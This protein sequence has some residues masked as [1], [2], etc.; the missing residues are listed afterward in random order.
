MSLSL[1][2]KWMDVDVFSISNWD[3]NFLVVEKTQ[4]GSASWKG[5]RC[6][7]TLDQCSTWR[8]SEQGIWKSEHPII[9]G[10]GPNLR[11]A[12]PRSH[13]LPP[14][15]YCICL[16][17]PYR[18]ICLYPCEFP[19]W[20]CDHFRHCKVLERV[21]HYRQTHV[22]RP[23]AGYKMSR[24]SWFVL[25]TCTPVQK[26]VLASGF[27]MKVTYYILYIIYYILYTLF[28]YIYIRIYYTV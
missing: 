10:L 24:L 23:T 7:I 5:L 21:R 11:T 19:M 17:R 1:G 22:H 20:S 2:K 4:I 13:C 25:I 12:G 15:I 26:S 14:Y 9:E 8:P 27:L 28:I 16:H 6:P 18:H 3:S